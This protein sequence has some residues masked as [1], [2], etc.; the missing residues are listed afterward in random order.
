MK[1]SFGKHKLPEENW[2]AYVEV[3]KQITKDQAHQI[4][5]YVYSSLPNTAKYA[6]ERENAPT[7]FAERVTDSRQSAAAAKFVVD[8]SC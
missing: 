6:S 3:A 2:E 1:Q 5:E 4:T 8:R 7:T